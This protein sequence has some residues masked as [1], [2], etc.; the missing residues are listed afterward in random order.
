ML[1]SDITPTP[2]SWLLSVTVG[3]RLFSDLVNYSP[4]PGDRGRKNHPDFF[5]RCMRSFSL[6]LCASVFQ[7]WLVCNLDKMSSSGD[8]T[9]SAGNRDM[10]RSL[11]EFCEGVPPP[12]TDSVAIVYQLFLCIYMVGRV[13][14]VFPFGCQF[15]SCESCTGRV[16]QTCHRGCANDSIICGTRF[17]KLYHSCPHMIY[18]LSITP[19]ILTSRPGI[20]LCCMVSCIMH[21]TGD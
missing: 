10:K 5:R 2:A 21:T 17:T 3:L 12:S 19:H 15:V 16:C 7:C 20:L 18:I 8:C 14:I 9:A 1:C 4:N 11:I 13:P 6:T